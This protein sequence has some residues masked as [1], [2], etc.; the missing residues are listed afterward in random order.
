MG[1]TRNRAARVHPARWLGC[2]L[3]RG[4]PLRRASD[5]VEGIGALLAILLVL[6]AVP[7]TVLIGMHIAAERADAAARARAD[8]RPATAVLLADAP[9]AVGADGMDSTAGTAQ[10]PARWHVAGAT[11]TGTV[12]ASPGLHRGTRVPVW[13]DRRGHPVSAPPTQ[14]QVAMSSVGTGLGLLFAILAGVGVGWLV[15]RLILDRA[16]LAAWERDWRRFNPHGNH[17]VR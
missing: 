14:S 6:A 7:V 17:W 15:L 10:V 9:A 12:A 13:L 1:P 2:R 5:R 11:R 16:R 8:R 3:R 4:N